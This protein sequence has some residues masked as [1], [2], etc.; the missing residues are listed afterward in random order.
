MRVENDNILDDL[1]GTDMSTDIEGPAISLEHIQGFS[2]Q[3]KWTGSPLGEILLEASN[4]VYS[5]AQ[6]ANV[7]NWIQIPNATVDVSAD[8][9]AFFHVPCAFYRWFRLRFDRISGSGTITLAQFM[10]KGV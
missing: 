3:V 10:V 5:E 2:V 6:K 4:D 7:S 8:D 1:T 9:E